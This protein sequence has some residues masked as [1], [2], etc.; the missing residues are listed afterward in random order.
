MAVVKEIQKEEVN[1]AT[2][3]NGQ[4]EEGAGMRS[5]LKKMKKKVKA[6]KWMKFT[7]ISATRIKNNKT[8]EHAML[9]KNLF[10]SL[11]RRTFWP[12]VFDWQAR[13]HSC[14]VYQCTSFTPWAFIWKL[15]VYLRL[16][17]YLQPTSE[18]R[19]KN[20]LLPTI[21]TNQTPASPL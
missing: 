8:M 15:A 1:F 13:G 20:R 11:A 10:S 7:V 21:S 17:T 18:W 6:S 5:F 3:K 19:R 9:S 2:K 14:H 4:D 16:K 12:S